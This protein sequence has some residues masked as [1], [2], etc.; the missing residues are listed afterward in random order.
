MGNM[1]DTGQDANH[2]LL[3]YPLP[4]GTKVNVALDQY[5]P[6]TPASNRYLRNL[7]IRC[8]GRRYHYG[9]HLNEIPHQSISFDLLFLWLH[10]RPQNYMMEPY[11]HS[12]PS[13]SE[14][15]RVGKECRSRWSPY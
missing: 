1:K 9:I 7:Y 8:P 6:L 10:N 5:R 12:P 14:E 4:P 2:H 11:E 3:E 15:R 13:R